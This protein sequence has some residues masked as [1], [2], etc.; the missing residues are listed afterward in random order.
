MVQNEQGTTKAPFCQELET[1]GTSA[2]MLA[3]KQIIHNP[4]LIEVCSGIN[5]S[6]LGM[7]W[8]SQLTPGEE[9]ETDIGLFG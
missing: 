7:I 6:K 4:G 3:E 9:D 8:T 1:A 2:S 5:T